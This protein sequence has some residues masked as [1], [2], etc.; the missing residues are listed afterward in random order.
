MIAG[1]GNPG[2]RYENTPHNAGFDVVDTLARRWGAPQWRGWK[3]KAAI[4]EVRFAGHE[5]LM[6]KPSTFMN[7]SGEAVKPLLNFRGLEP[8]D[9]LV[10]CDDIAL[11][12]GRTRLRAGG[13]S[14]GQKGLQNIIDHLNTAEIA[15]LRLGVAPDEGGL[16][17]AAE[18]WVLSK[19]APMAR[20][21][22][23][24][25]IEQAVACIETWLSDGLQRAMTLHNGRRVDDPASEQGET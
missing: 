11:P 2:P 5:V 1:L 20:E 24:Q 25:V 13:S 8:E 3:S 19:W 4:T 17:C 23:N 16:P 6:V 22:F 9:L 18:R 14:G 7:L 15:R 10:V 12:L 21:A